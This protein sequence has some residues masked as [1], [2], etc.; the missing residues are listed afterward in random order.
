MNKFLMYSNGPPQ[1]LVNQIPPCHLDEEQFV[2]IKREGEIFLNKMGRDSSP[3]NPGF[4]MTAFARGAPVVAQQQPHAHDRQLAK[5][6]D[7]PENIT[8]NERELR[9]PTATT[10]LDCHFEA[11]PK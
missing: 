5:L 6:R 11:C 7:G 3:V 9:F 10:N 4:G 8:A 2:P 1:V